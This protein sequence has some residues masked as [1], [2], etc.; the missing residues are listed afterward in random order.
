MNSE[1]KTLIQNPLFKSTKYDNL[2]QFMNDYSMLLNNYLDI[3]SSI[4][5]GG[6]FNPETYID[7]I[8]KNTK[9]C[10]RVLNFGGICKS[11]PINN[12]INLS[13][14]LDDNCNLYNCIVLELNTNPEFN[15][16]TT[17]K[18]NTIFEAFKTDID[19]KNVTNIKKI[20]L[21][22]VLLNSNTKS[23]LFYRDI[24]P[25]FV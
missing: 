1:I 22:G 23:A 12:A 16:N 19:L 14:Y 20:Y 4:L 6:A 2:T 25:I 10:G 5:I 18:L 13:Y 3:A 17:S 11:L 9:I 8:I 24:T 15:K 7:G 21:D